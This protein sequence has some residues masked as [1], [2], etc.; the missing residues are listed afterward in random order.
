MPIT[1]QTTGAELAGAIRENV[2]SFWVVET[3]AGKRLFDQEPS[4]AE[5]I[6]Y[7]MWAMVDSRS[8]LQAYAFPV[9][10]KGFWGPIEGLMSVETDGVTIRTVVW[11]RHSETPG[12]GGRIDEPQYREKFRGK[13]AS[14]DIRLDVVPD[15]TMGDNPHK[16]D[17]ITG[18]T[19]TTV[20]GMEAFL[21]DNFKKWH[22]YLPL[23]H[24]YFQ[25]AQRDAEK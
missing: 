20:V 25:R 24:E 16:I 7:H 5:K 15:G 22:E 3:T 10:G 1:P 14:P 12:L 8:D 17:Q 18:A 23:L 21:N 2:R 19:Q 4:P 13:L 11:T 9:G 6:I